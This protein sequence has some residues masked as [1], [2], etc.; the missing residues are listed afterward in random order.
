MGKQARDAPPKY[1]HYL[2]EWR[3]HRKM[4]QE[5]LANLLGTSKTVVSRW[6]RGSRGL[7]LRTQ[8]RLMAALDITPAEFFAPPDKPPFDALLKEI[9]DPVE[10][11]R[12]D[13]QLRRMF[14]VLRQK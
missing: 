11:A 6:E 1:R 10:A 13:T 4:R 5:D 7:D 12:V 2:K 9:T 14:D 3:Q 8:F